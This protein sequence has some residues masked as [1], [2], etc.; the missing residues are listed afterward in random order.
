MASYRLLANKWQLPKS[1]SEMSESQQRRGVII[2]KILSENKLRI[3]TNGH[4]E[5]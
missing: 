5:F 2:P 4:N 3:Q 1:L